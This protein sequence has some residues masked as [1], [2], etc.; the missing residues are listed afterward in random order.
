MSQHATPGFDLLAFAHPILINL[1]DRPER[2]ADSLGELSAA[3]G[4]PVEAGRDVHLVRPVRFEDRAGFTRVGYRSNTHA[5]LQA[6][7]WAR[8]SGRERVL[9]LE[10][11]LAFGTSWSQWG[12]ILL[13]RLVERSWHLA[14]LGYRDDWGEAPTLPD[15]EGGRGGVDGMGGRVPMA[16][17]VGWARF[18]GRV[19]G[20]HAY[21]LHASALDEWIDHLR[22]I[23]DGTPGDGLRG[24]MASDGAINTFVWVDPRRIRL[25]ALPVLVGTRPTRSDIAPQLVD[26]LP[27]VGNG[28]EALRRW[29]RARRPEASINYR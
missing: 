4:R 29:Y 13:E 25:L 11:D 14:S 22:T 1:P 2:L 27:V 18:A 19:N 26:R 28:A 16:G 7:E 10:D 5:H 17:S 8:A 12:A 24:P 21:L 15:G 3:T 23:L 9:V 20:A 6:A